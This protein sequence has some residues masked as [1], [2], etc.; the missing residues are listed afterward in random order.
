MVRGCGSNNTRRY[1]YHRTLGCLSKQDLAAR[2]SCNLTLYKDKYGKKIHLAE[3]G[4]I[5]V[6]IGEKELS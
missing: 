2:P 6:Q 5:F 1:A 3:Y 4:K